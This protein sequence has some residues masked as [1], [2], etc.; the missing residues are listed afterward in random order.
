MRRNLQLSYGISAVSPTRIHNPVPP[1]R[2]A[3]SKSNRTSISQYSLSEEGKKKKKKKK[4][5]GR[6][7]IEIERWP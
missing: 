7:E 2:I 5:Y 4:N 6:I 3:A 1:E